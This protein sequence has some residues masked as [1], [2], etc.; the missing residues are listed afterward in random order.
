[1]LFVNV[2]S[3]L[4]DVSGSRART[5]LADLLL[6]STGHL[7]VEN[8]VSPNYLLMSQSQI[9]HAICAFTNFVQR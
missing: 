6:P 5:V 3:F 4:R 7:F 2:A 8:D 9:K 1:M